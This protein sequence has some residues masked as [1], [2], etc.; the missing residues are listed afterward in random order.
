MFKNTLLKVLTI[1]ILISSLFL[2]SCTT[3]EKTITVQDDV[4]KMSN[5]LDEDGRVFTKVRDLDMPEID[6]A[7]IISV[8]NDSSPVFFRQFLND[9]NELYDDLFTLRADNSINTIENNLKGISIVTN[10]NL[11]TYFKDT[12]LWVYDANTKEKKSLVNL[13]DIKE[14]SENAKS[15]YPLK[16]SGDNT[17]L[18]IISLIQYEGYHENIIRILDLT[19]DK[20]HKSAPLKDMHLSR[21]VLY[22]KVTDK[23][24]TSTPYSEN[25]LEFSLDDM[26]PKE[27]IRVPGINIE[28][29]KMSEDGKYIYFTQKDRESKKLSFCKF[30]LQSKNIVPL[31]KISPKEKDEDLFWT[32]FDIVGNTLVYAF[33]TNRASDYESFLTKEK[34]YAANI[35]ED[36]LTNTQLL[37]NSPKGEIS[38]LG[39]YLSEDGTKLLTTV[40][41][42]SPP[43]GDTSKSR[44]IS[45][46]NSIYQKSK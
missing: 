23:F 16:I 15:M 11:I 27:I 31:L 21:N 12:E 6:G 35:S 13:P 10:K 3:E 9:S 32:N 34:L 7:S 41:I 19:T 45:T 5:E 18:S 20:I 4:Q 22:S 1:S 29:F 46:Q 44:I 24:Y 17:Y 38:A 40:S 36:S 39:F 25:I 30:D 8:A 28:N 43:E 42:F 37:Y 26:N 14:E 33:F 2:T